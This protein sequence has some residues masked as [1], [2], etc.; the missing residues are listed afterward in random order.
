M[1]RKDRELVGKSESPEDGKFGNREDA[2]V[3]QATK[4]E[5][6]NCSVFLTFG[7]SDFRTQ[8]ALAYPIKYPYPLQ[9]LFVAGVG[10]TIIY[11]EDEALHAHVKLAVVGVALGG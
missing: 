9:V 4:S 6:E 10:D 8:Q 7:L 2:G 5:G 11:P 3:L 1:S